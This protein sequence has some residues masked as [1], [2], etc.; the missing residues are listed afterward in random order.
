MAKKRKYLTAIHVNVQVVHCLNSGRT[1]ALGQILNPKHVA[2]DTLIE[3]LL[4]VDHFKV[5]YITHLDIIFKVTVVILTP[6]SS[7]LRLL[8]SDA[9][10]EEEVLT[11]SSSRVR[12]HLCQ[13][14]SH[15]CENDEKEEEHSEGIGDTVVQHLS[16]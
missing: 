12:H 16:G 6:K 1:V 10:A 15:C 4:L 8:E 14:D 5:A 3:V 7:E 9:E 2:G 11:E 13:V